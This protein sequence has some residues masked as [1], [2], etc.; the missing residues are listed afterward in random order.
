MTDEAERFWEER[1]QERDR[2][3]SGRANPVLVDVVGPLPAGAALDL[4]CGEGGDAVWLAGLGWQVTAVDVSATALS[5]ASAAAEAAGVEARIDFQRHDLAHSFPSGA[6][7]L[8]SAQFLQSPV[9]FPRDRVL[10][11]AARAVA[12]GGLLLIVEH[13]AFPPWARHHEPHPRFPSPEETLAVLDLSPGQWRTERLGSP[14]R[15]ATGPDGQRG[16]LIDNVV[17]VRRL[18]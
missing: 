10:R 12:S 4:G 2:V 16:T 9:E 14:E 8:V 17:A 18:A 7:D 11:A 1:Y 5:R 6:F 15:E 3:W 13:G